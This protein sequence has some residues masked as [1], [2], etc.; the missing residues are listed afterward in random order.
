MAGLAALVIVASTAVAPIEVHGSDE[1]Q[2]RPGQAVDLPFLLT[3]D[4]DVERRFH[5]EVTTSASGNGTWQ[6]DPDQ[7]SATL[8][9]NETRK[10]NAS[11]RP[12]RNA[13]NGTEATITIEAES[14]P[15][16][17]QASCLSTRAEGSITFTVRVQTA[18]QETNGSSG[19]DTATAGS[20]TSEPRPGT[21]ANG[22]GDA[23][24]SDDEATQ[25]GTV[26]PAGPSASGEGA[27]WALGGVLL[28]GL[29]LAGAVVAWRRRGSQQTG[30]GGG[31]L[32]S[33]EPFLGKYEVGEEIGSG[34]FG[35][36]F[37]A[38]HRRLEREVVIKRLHPHLDRD[39]EVRERFERE[40][41]ILAGLDH[42]HVV[43][44]YDVE[45][46]A[47]TDYLVMEF[48][49]GGSLADRLERGRLDPGRA[50]DTAL[51]LLDGLGHVHREGVV[52]RDL[53]PSNLLITSEGELKIGDFGIAHAARLR[54][55]MATQADSSP[56]GT[57][58]YMAPE[59]AEG[60]PGDERSDLYSA[61]VILYEALTGRWHLGDRPRGP[62]A[63]SRAFS[64]H[65]VELPV[66]GVSAEL[67]AVLARG[68]SRDP[69]ERF[70]SAQAFADA[71]GRC[72]EA[73]DGR[74]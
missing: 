18:D 57:P 50:V 29:V 7:M 72:P 32:A 68:L 22:T 35:T 3:N 36:V 54:A 15:T 46:E 69:D 38:R 19:N 55:T 28:G 61:A 34:S 63:L 5:V 24:A 27:P 10:F 26:D 60:R 21:D 20:N 16:S 67:N 47:D 17:V 58:L 43:R 42:P 66:D 25:V 71:L 59:Q 52:H 14:C 9:S 49:D 51:Q 70:P 44:V 13:T 2:T 12:P 31:R 40:A 62:S 53:K 11:T 4:G 48:V 1:K 37:R 6:T 39:E 45:Q 30:S 41:R 23:N 64:E 33:D 56:T 8:A 65:E 73:P 74:G